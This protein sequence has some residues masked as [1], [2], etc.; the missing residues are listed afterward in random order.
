MNPSKEM[1]WKDP[2]KQLDIGQPT[3]VKVK[4]VKEPSHLKA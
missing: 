4:D 3:K 1:S 2:K